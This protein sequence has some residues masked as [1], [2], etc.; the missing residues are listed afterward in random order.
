M[1]FYKIIKKI[2]EIMTTKQYYYK[3]QPVNKP[4]SVM[5]NGGMVTNPSDQILK[6]LG[7][8]IKIVETK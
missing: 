7:Y 5:F 4:F 8:E 2:F 3:G 1:Q 6:R